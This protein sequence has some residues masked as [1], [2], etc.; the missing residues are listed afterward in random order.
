[1]EIKILNQE[2]MKN[3]ERREVRQEKKKKTLLWL[4]LSLFFLQKHLTQMSVG[5]YL[6]PNANLQTCRLMPFND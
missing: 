3:K 4:M 1:M 6:F 5:M 2:E